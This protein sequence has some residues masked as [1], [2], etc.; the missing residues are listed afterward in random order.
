M[1][2]SGFCVVIL[3]SGSSTSLK[4][5]FRV[6]ILV[7]LAGFWLRWVFFA[8]LSGFD[9]NSLLLR[10]CA[11]FVVFMSCFRLGRG[12]HLPVLCDNSR[13]FF[14]STSLR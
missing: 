3:V 8:V 4:C 12:G 13:V 14:S 7:L 9:G 6:V 11:F 2:V 10:R 1:V 5:V